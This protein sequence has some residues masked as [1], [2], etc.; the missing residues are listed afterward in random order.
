VR[1]EK[2]FA[3]GVDEN[4]DSRHA[5]GRPS[6]TPRAFLAALGIAAL[7]WIAIAAALLSA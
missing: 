2:H 4:F 5:N 7:L 1:H 3:Y 6:R